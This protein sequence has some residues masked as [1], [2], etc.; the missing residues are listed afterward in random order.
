MNGG[1]KKVLSIIHFI[2]NDFIQ[3]ITKWM[4]R[5]FQQHNSSDNLILV[6][7]LS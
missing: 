4:A 6:H 5:G 7:Y 1:G 3:N 2:V